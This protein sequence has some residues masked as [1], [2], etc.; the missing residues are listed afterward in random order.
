MISETYYLD[1]FYIQTSCKDNKTVISLLDVVILLDTVIV[2]KAITL[3]FKNHKETF[4]K[5]KL[6]VTL[7]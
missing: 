2:P 3:N 1:P 4:N 6:L 7:S 5:I